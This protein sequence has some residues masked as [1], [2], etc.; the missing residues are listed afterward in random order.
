MG[1][2]GGKKNSPDL[3]RGLTHASERRVNNLI[4]I[5]LSDSTGKKEQ[6]VIIIYKSIVDVS[7]DAQALSSMVQ[8]EA[9]LVTAAEAAA[10]VSEAAAAAEAAA[11]TV[12]VHQDGV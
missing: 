2:K 11:V 12:S 7:V 1:K 5:L 10:T 4:F 3:G 8:V 9:D 6:N